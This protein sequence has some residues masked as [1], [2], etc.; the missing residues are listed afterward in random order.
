MMLDKGMRK[1][2][3]EKALEGKGDFV[4]IDHLSS[5]L[6]E[7]LSADIR[8]FVC[9]KL[10]EIYEKKS[11]FTEAAKMYDTA[12]ICAIS[13]SDKIKYYVKETELLIKGGVFQ[14]ADEAMRKAMTDANAS[15][16]AEVYFV[17]KDF[18]K[19]QAEI[20]EKE[21]RRNNAV[22]IYEKLL[23]MNISDTE[24]RE[25][26]EKLLKLYEKLGKIKEYCILKKGLE[27]SL[28]LKK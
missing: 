15:E 27:E 1:E 6:N 13:F 24:R 25:I 3:I 28:N 2:E 17:L 5:F 21:L 16:R 12:A 22:K 26:K 8:K 7:N 19:R 14:R 10:A 20:Y 4:R 23:E 9:L 11:M 18:Y